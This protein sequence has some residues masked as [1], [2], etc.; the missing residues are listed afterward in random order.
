MGW[1]LLTNYVTTSLVV[2]N[3]TLEFG[4]SVDERP[5]TGLIRWYQVL[6]SNH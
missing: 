4:R 6:D 2:K 5:K 3:H 1:S